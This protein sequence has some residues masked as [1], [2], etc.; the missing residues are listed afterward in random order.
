MDDDG[1]TMRAEAPTPADGRDAGDPPG[2]RDQVGST[3]GAGK[4]L[5]D[6]HVNLAKT[7]IGEIVGEVTRMV[8][9]I[10]AAIGVVILAGLLL[11]IGLI[12]FLGEWLFGSIGWGVLLGFLLLIDV[13][14][15]AVLLAFDVKGSRLGTSLIVAA[16]VGIAV[17]VVMGLDLTHRGWTALGD[18]VWA[19]GDPNNRAVILAAGI[20]AFVLGVLGFISGIRAGIGGAIGR[21]IAGAL[22]G[23]I[24]GLVTVVSIPTQVGAA[25]G[26]LVALLAFPVVAGWDLY[27]KGVD[28]EALKQKFI[29]NNTID[30]TKETIE[31][32]RART[33]LVPKS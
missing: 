17:G 31:W 21:L 23:A 13:A 28:S 14:I 8:G 3:F 11:G 26:V 4:R 6:A 27:R 9:L 7:E 15:V 19:A 32:V 30:L 1:S 10:G 12:L 5:L 16:V 33:P 20:S 2:I 25:L 29:P 22:L 24:L 18:T